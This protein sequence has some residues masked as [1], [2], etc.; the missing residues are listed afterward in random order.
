M[1]CNTEEKQAKDKEKPEEVIFNI[2][3]LI[4]YLARIKDSRK[5]QGIRYSLV[6][7]LVVMILAKLCGEDKP[8]GIADWTQLRSGWLIERLQLKYKRLPHHS[9]YRR[10]LSDVMDENE[11][12]GIVDR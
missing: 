4:S 2:G 11:F 7:I 12:E 5:P 9:T 1:K 3:S 10:I 8:F 6:T